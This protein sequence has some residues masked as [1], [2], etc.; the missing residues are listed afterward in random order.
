MTTLYTDLSRY[1]DVMCSEINYLAQSQS[2][3]RLNQLFGN[4]GK[5]HL[6]MACGTGLHLCH[7]L[8]QGFDSSGLDISQSMLNIA[9]QRCPLAHFLRGEMS[10][11]SLTCR[12]DLISCFLYS[13]HYTNPS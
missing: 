8:Q 2:V 6:D 4:G 10:Q 11:F 5:R 1:Y 9:Q 7:F 12:V 3:I 13:L